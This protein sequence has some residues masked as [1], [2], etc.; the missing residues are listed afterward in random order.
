MEKI[1]IRDGKIRIRD[2]HSGS[3]KLLPRS[4]WDKNSRWESEYRT[5]ARLDWLHKISCFFIQDALPNKKYGKTGIGISLRNF[6]GT[7]VFLF[8][9]LFIQSEMDW[10]KFR[11][12]KNKTG[13]GGERYEYL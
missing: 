4:N 2:K 13:P 7:V 10:E 8:S 11:T 6:L 3:T 12:N 1:R 5:V 9:V